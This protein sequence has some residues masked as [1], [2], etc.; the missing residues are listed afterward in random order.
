MLKS[1]CEL[2]ALPIKSFSETVDPTCEEHLLG[3]QLP[4][5]EVL[6]LTG[7]SSINKLGRSGRKFVHIT[8]FML[9]SLYY[10]CVSSK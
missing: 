6:T 3:K 5:S 7:Y 2:S 9:H 8:I 1:K 10:V 4:C